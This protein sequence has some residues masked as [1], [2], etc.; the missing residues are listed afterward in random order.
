M[1]ALSPAIN[2][3]VPA[4]ATV[5]QCGVYAEMLNGFF[6]WFAEN[7]ILGFKMNDA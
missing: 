4:T 1:L 6:Q 5:L 2:S 7:E 3:G